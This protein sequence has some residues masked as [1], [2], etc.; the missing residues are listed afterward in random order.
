MS[1]EC[2]TCGRTCRCEMVKQRPCGFC[3]SHVECGYCGELVCYDEAIVVHN[4]ESEVCPDCAD[5]LLAICD[6]CGEMWYRSDDEMW[7]SS[8]SD[9][10]DEDICPE[11]RKEV[12]KDDD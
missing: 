4:G 10:E 11:C 9:D 1:S 5:E 3:E 8:D 7:N 6:V 2:V 12:D